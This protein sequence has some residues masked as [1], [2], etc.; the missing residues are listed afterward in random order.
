[1]K[2]N[3]GLATVFYN[4]FTTSVDTPVVL[5]M[6]SVDPK[7]LVVISSLLLL[8]LLFEI[9]CNSLNALWY[10]LKTLSPKTF[11]S[12]IASVCTFCFYWTISRG[13][14]TRFQPSRQM[15][16]LRTIFSPS[17]SST[18]FQETLPIRYHQDLVASIIFFF[19]CY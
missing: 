12:F 3:L 14:K 11:M 6:A 17:C 1:M 19:F 10:C 15:E 7:C 4:K 8:T 5:S 18:L 9:I 13:L 2:L 16:F